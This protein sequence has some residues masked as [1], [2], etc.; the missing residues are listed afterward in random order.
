MVW[1]FADMECCNICEGPM[2]IE[3]QQ[4]NMYG[5]DMPY[6]DK[7]LYQLYRGECLGLQYV[8]RCYL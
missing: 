6:Q 2:I 3:I 1:E 4:R 5:W 8:H 7:K